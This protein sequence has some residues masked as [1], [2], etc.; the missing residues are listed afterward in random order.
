M[1][2]G[3]LVRPRFQEELRYGKSCLT[4]SK[5]FLYLPGLMVVDLYATVAAYISYCIDFTKIFFS[6]YPRSYGN[7]EHA[8]SYKV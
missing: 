3:C 7:R 5:N 8:W 6:V 1:C 4:C 2:D